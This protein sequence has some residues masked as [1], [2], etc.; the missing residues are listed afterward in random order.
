MSKLPGL[1]QFFGDEV[2]QAIAQ[3]GDGDEAHAVKGLFAACFGLEEDRTRACTAYI[4]EAL[5]HVVELKEESTLFVRLSKRYGAGDP[6]L[7]AM[8]LMQQ[9]HLAPGQA[10]FIGPNVP[11]AYLEG[12]LI[13]CMACSDNV[14]RAGLTPKY[15]DVGTLLEVV[16]CSSSLDGVHDP[17]RGGDGFNVV[18]APAEEFRLKFL[19]ESS[20]RAVIEEGDAPA[21]VLCVGDG[22][23][24]R[25]RETGRRLDLV[26]GGAALLPPCTGAYDVETSRAILVYGTV[27]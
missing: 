14:V 16:E 9:V 17:V 1:R 10:I 27:G 15:K 26:D 24:I 22:A 4:A 5:P 23:T 25:S 12:D 19:P 20:P 21:V 7:I 18:S 3:G 6:G 11:H 8:L 2:I 13:E